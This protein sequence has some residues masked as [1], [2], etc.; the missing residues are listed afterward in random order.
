MR[1]LPIVLGLFGAAHVCLGAWV[2]WSVLNAPGDDNPFGLLAFAAM[3]M[4]IVP[5]YGLVLEGLREPVRRHGVWL[6]LA[7]VVSVLLTLMTP[8]LLGAWW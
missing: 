1:R 3:L 8:V 5:G 6:F 7:S 2:F 4:G